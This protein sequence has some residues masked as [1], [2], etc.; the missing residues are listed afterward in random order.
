MALELEKM[1][2][3]IAIVRMQRGVQRK[4]KMTSK[5]YA[6]ICPDFEE[7]NKGDY[8]VCEVTR[9]TRKKNVEHDFRVGRVEDIL[10]WDDKTIL[11]FRPNSFIVCKVEDSE[12][13]TKR[14]SNIKNKK[15]SLWARYN[16]IDKKRP[17]KK[18]EGVPMNI[19]DRIIDSNGKLHF[20]KLNQYSHK[21]RIEK[22]SMQ[23]N[24]NNDKNKQ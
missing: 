16:A 17:D 24:K 4:V 12:N 22:K 2:L 5:P 7:I 15:Y 13:F 10:T 3:K 1:E 19:F 18:I 21:M 9:K 14:C 23:N 8:V 6:F 20:E 11:Q